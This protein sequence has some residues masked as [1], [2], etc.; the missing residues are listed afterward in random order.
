MT[1]VLSTAFSHGL[2]Q[3][4]HPSPLSFPPPLPLPLPLPLLYLLFLIFK[5]TSISWCEVS[6]LT[7]L[8][9]F[10][11]LCAGTH[12]IHALILGRAITGLQAFTGR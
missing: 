6:F 3:F 8:P 10:I 12:D 9:S 1:D 7:A 11:F 2:G 4:G 5:D